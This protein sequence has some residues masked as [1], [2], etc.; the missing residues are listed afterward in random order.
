MKFFIPVFLLILFL[1][2][3]GHAQA[4]DSLLPPQTQLASEQ[5]DPE[6]AAKAYITSLS[7]EKRA[8]SD[9]Y[10][11]GN[12]WHMLWA[13]LI[14]F[15]AAIVFLYFGLSKWMKK[16][17]S[18]VKNI[19]L[20]NLIYIVL[21]FVFSFVIALPYSIY[22]GFIREHRFGLSNMNFGAWFKEEMIGL[23]VNIILLGLLLLV[24]YY[25][26]RKTKERWWIWAGGIST[27]F[28]ILMIF[29][30]PVFLAPLFNDYSELPD[31]PLKEEILSLARANGIPTNNVYQFDASKQSK[32]ISANVNGIGS[33]IRISLNDNLLN[34]CNRKEI[35]AVMAHEMG[36]YVLHHV[37][38]LILLFSIMFFVGFWL[39]HISFRWLWRRWGKR[40]N[41]RDISD[42]ASLPLLMVILVFFLFVSTPLINNIVR[43]DE[44]E[45]DIFGLNAA[46]EPDGF[47][48]VAMML[49][50]YRKV[51]P[52]HWEEILLYDHPSPRS[53]VIMAMQWKAENLN[54]DSELQEVKEE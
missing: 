51:S 16:I 21:Y 1:Q 11:E 44:V 32:R 43:Q 39:L 12:Y 41:I 4:T 27:V 48:S 38:R 50:E 52:G 28:I 25:I 14:E 42:I 19:N 30:S 40:W 36:H 8:V 3:T 13:L 17:S 53:R 29:I 49:S 2:L 45:A 54:E 35:R 23:L 24:I 31:G 7:A 6:M 46:R 18:F 10:S 47:A 37:Q 34:R 15:L 9:K 5:F 33:T 20:Q 26:M 22:K